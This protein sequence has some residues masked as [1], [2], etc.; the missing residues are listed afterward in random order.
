MSCATAGGE[1]LETYLADIDLPMLTNED[2]AALEADMIVEEVEVI[3]SFAARKSPG[4]N[5][6]PSEWY[7]TFRN[8]IVPRLL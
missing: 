5:G 1:A 4:L 2:R 8:N 3:S 7:S 6:L